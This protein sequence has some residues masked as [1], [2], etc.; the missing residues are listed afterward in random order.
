VTRLSCGGRAGFCRRFHRVAAL[1]CAAVLWATPLRAQGRVEGQVRTADSIPVAGV[2]LELHR[3]TESS[4]GLADSTWSDGTGRFSFDFQ[5]SADSG[6]VWLVGARYEG[7]LYWGSPIHDA[8]PEPITDY[9]VVVYDTARVD[10]PDPDLA[11]PFRHL[12]LTPSP[13]GFQVEDIIDVGGRADRTLLSSADTVPVWTTAL[14]AGAHAV[15]PLE[16]GVPAD[17]L[18]LGDGTVGYAG[19]LPPAGVRIVLEYVVPGE[20]FDLRIEHPTGRMEL[21]V[22]PQPAMRLRVEGLEEGRIG[23]E[24]AASFRRF[25]GVD[26]PAGRLVSART[27]WSSGSRRFAW[28]WLLAAAVLGAGALLSTRYSRRRS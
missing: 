7:V 9:P 1:L 28:V 24:M 10:A 4:G 13:G 26:V 14:A 16:G 6:A 21:L 15:I 20:S 23:G 22:V 12:V 18:I 3:V 2:R 25:S 19:P 17:D 11:T 5:A 8:G 27:E